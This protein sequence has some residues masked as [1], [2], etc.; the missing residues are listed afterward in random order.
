M[1]RVFNEY[2]TMKCFLQTADNSGESVLANFFT[3]LLNKKTGQNKSQL[4]PRGTF[5]VART[6]AA[7]ASLTQHSYSVA[8]MSV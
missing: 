7:A 3:T 6:P 5:N 4:Y 8:E 1:L 2:M